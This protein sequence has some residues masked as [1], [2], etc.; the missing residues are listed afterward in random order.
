MKDRRQREFI[1]A[2]SDWDAAASD[3][4]VLDGIRTQVR[5]CAR[6]CP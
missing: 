4:V 6:S 2:A 1:D 3:R 5:V